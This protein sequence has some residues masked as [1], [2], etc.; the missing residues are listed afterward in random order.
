MQFGVH[1]FVPLFV[2]ILVHTCN[3]V[4]KHKHLKLYILV[5]PHT[6]L[7][8]LY[9]YALCL[10]LS[11]VFVQSLLLILGRCTDH[12]KH[13]LVLPL[14]GEGLSPGAS[15]AEVSPTAGNVLYLGR[16]D[17]ICGICHLNTFLYFFDFA[18]FICKWYMH[19]SVQQH[20]ML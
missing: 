10:S 1:V 8:L 19:K 20:V 5:L 14:A 13:I 15:G 6:G 18:F 11:L 16:C 17:A 4:H 7:S 12:C 9:N 2:H 3:S